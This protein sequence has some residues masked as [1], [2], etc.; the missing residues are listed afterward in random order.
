[1]SEISYEQSIKE[2]EIQAKKANEAIQQLKQRVKELESQNSS[3]F[4]RDILQ[5]LQELKKTME[6][7]KKQADAIIAQKNEELKRMKELETENAKLK[8][9]IKHLVR[10]LDELEEKK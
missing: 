8:Y 2:L 7:E 10:A 1:M 9:R 5:K 6:E 3:E 4:K